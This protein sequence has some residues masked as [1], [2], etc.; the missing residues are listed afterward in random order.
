MQHDWM[1]NTQA[2]CC[3]G[4]HPRFKSSNE[5][6]EPSNTAYTGVGQQVPGERAIY[7]GRT[8]ADLSS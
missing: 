5:T 8:V 2:R 1:N 3:A 6:N 7:I 4:S